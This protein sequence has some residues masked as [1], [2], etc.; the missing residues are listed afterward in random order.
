MACQAQEL[1]L[2]YLL[3]LFGIIQLI[4]MHLRTGYGVSQ[5]SYTGSKSKPFQGGI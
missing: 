3:I 5:A 2:E 1:L 4:E